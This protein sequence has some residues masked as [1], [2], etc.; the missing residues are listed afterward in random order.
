MQCP[1]CHQEHPDQARFCPTTGRVI[2]S[3]RYCPNCG[4]A[5]QPDWRVC[6]FCGQPTRTQL[7]ATSPA[8]F[9][10]GSS[11]Q[12][13]VMPAWLLWGGGGLLAIIVIL[14]IAAIVFR[15]PGR[16]TGRYDAVAE[17]M[18]E[19]TDLY[20][21]LNLLELIQT[22]DSE[23]LEILGIP[24]MMF[25]G[26][27]LDGPSDLPGFDGN[28]LDLQTAINTS[29][30]EAYGINLNDDVIPWIGQYAGIGFD[31]SLDQYG[32]PDLT[33]GLIVALEV[34]S[35]GAADDFLNKLR[36]NMEYMHEV[37]F[38]ELEYQGVRVYTAQGKDLSFGRIGGLVA[39]TTS[40]DKLLSMIDDIEKNQTLGEN[41]VYKRLAVHAPS[42][43][44]ARVFIKEADIVDDIYKELGSGL[45]FFSQLM[46]SPAAS[47]SQGALI[48]VIIKEDNLKFDSLTALDP[49]E[50]TKE[51]LEDIGRPNDLLSRLPD[52]SLIVFSGNDLGRSL[53]Q[54]F[55]AEDG[56]EILNL[57]FGKGWAD[58]LFNYL[59]GDWVLSFNPGQEGLLYQ[60]GLPFGLVLLARSDQA[61]ELEQ[62]FNMLLSLVMLD[63]SIQMHNY[64]FLDGYLYELTVRDG[65]RSEPVM[66]YSTTDEYLL[67]GSST[68]SI[69]GLYEKGGKLT[70][71]SKYRN[72]TSNISSGLHQI[73]YFDV[74]GSFQKLDQYYGSASSDLEGLE[75]YINN[76]NAISAARG[77]ESGN[78][79]HGELI[80][81]TAP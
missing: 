42:G 71:T 52:D 32:Y 2:E 46:S 81:M 69:K 37:R 41:P 22:Q 51:D 33:D 14:L 10:A 3:S 28:D 49:E 74:Q 76:I 54:F 1:H 25:I 44:I 23:Q 8:T 24:L 27:G 15:L 79:V 35:S 70:E 64:P 59:D 48:S 13:P 6:G 39:F 68:N 67:L 56:D 43:S 26:T 63:G 75:R 31:I 50:L 34:R 57:Y 47:A 66:A 38:S 36:G 60:N 18:P 12:Q 53:R 58:N 80:I 72:I 7:G 62:T 5:V 19:S 4:N 65:T 73:F 11:I 21:G 29:L 55:S 45:F 77:I 17:K 30:Q 78:V 20:L 16:L 9:Q 61:Q 40:E